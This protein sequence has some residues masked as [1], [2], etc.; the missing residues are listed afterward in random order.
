MDTKLYFYLEPYVYVIRGA[1]GALLVNLIDDFSFICTDEL[2][3]SIIDMLLASPTRT[4]IITNKEHRS[5]LVNDAIHH[6]MGNLINAHEAPFQPYTEINVVSGKDAYYKSVMY[7]RYNISSFISEGTFFLNTNSNDST[8]FISCITG[9]DT[10][11][12][13]I[14]NNPLKTFSPIEVKESICNLQQLNTNIKLNFC[15]LSMEYLKLFQNIPNNQHFTYYFSQ[16]T[17]SNNPDMQEFL[18]KKHVNFCLIV[19][20]C[21]NLL[22]ISR[23]YKPSSIW[24]K[25][26]TASELEIAYSLCNNITNL[27]LFPILT[28]DNTSFI[29]SL[30]SFSKEELLEINNK[31]TTI[32][33]NNLINSNYWG[34]IYLLPDKRIYYSL[35]RKNNTL[36]SSDNFYEN[37][38]RAY[39]E[40]SLDWIKIRAYQPCLDCIFRSLCPSPNYLEDSLRIS[41][42]L[43]CLLS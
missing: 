31:Y 23:N 30:I 6:F 3:L 33:L 15:G 35:L 36:H 8:E 9:D 38:K 26:S 14:L 18:E 16:S 13:E 41:G 19:D 37:Y 7:S 42:S 22:Q 40:G 29:R 34:K 2:S 21:D 5:H 1:N 28:S 24:L 10:T 17:L 43:D 27:Q 4:T 20:S 39:Y 25:I 12:P 11:T 32:K